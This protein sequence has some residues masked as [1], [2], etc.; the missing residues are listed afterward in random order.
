M[1]VLILVIV[2]LFICCVGNQFLFFPEKHIRIN[3]SYNVDRL[4][5]TAAHLY[6]TR[7]HSTKK[8]LV[9]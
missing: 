5:I 4:V 9:W 2:C 8:I 6:Q 7:K 3:R 1:E